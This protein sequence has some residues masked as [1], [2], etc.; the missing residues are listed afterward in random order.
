MTNPSI[1]KNILNNSGNLDVLGTSL[2]FICS[3]PRKYLI[4]IA[5]FVQPAKREQLKRSF[6]ISK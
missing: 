1:N 5:I 2:T 3:F 6:S 4:G